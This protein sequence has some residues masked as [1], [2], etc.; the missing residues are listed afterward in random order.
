[1]FFL[2][3][4]SGPMDR[5]QRQFVVLSNMLGSL[6]NDGQ[7]STVVVCVFYISIWLFYL[8]AKFCKVYLPNV[9]SHSRPNL[10]AKSSQI[11]YNKGCQIFE[12]QASRPV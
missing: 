4:P 1:M 3:S 2:I 5:E 8:V 11:S 6:K 7:E 10:Q 12:N 9:S